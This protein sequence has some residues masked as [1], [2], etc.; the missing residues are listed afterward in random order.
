MA[1]GFTPME[2]R[3]VRMARSGVEQSE[4]AHRFRKSPGFVRRVID[5][6]QVPRGHRDG[7]S[8]E[9][10]RPLERRVLKWRADGASLADVASRFRRSPRS[11]EQIERLANYK[12]QS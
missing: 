5:L 11:I 9:K 2:R 12:Q 10:L 8:G 6:A 1:D 7:Q 3:M 4:I